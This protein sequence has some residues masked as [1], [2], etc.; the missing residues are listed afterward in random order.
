MFH[1]M[2][3]YKQT[4]LNGVCIQDAGIEV[5]S[6]SMFCSHQIFVNVFMFTL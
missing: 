4:K 5:F 3:F 6:V 2:P 1:V